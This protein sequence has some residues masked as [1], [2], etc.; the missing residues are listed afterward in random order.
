MDDIF[1]AALFCFVILMFALF[2]IWFLTGIPQKIMFNK[3]VEQ[4]YYNLGQ[5]QYKCIELT[6]K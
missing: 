1:F 3:C 4:G 6:P 5:K 2:G